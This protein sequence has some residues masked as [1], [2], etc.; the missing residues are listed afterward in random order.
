LKKV[1]LALLLFGC[2]EALPDKDF[3]RECGV[4]DEMYSHT[5]LFCGGTDVDDVED[6]FQVCTHR[7]RADHQEVDCVPNFDLIEFG[8]G[9]DVQHVCWRQQ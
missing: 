3:G 5:V 2:G 6:V 4:H 1:V 7:N 8:E 9:C